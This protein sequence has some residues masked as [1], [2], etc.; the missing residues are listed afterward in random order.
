MTNKFKATIVLTVFL[1][2]P[3]LSLMAESIPGSGQE[4]KIEE[5]TKK[6]YPS[7]VRVEVRNMIKKVATGVVIEKNGYIVTTA[8]ISPRDEKISVITSDGK[9]IDA[10]FLGMDSETHL[11]LIQAKDKNLTP[12]TMGNTKGLSP[13]S[14]IGV[15]SISPENMPA[16]T[17]GIVSSLSQDWLRLNV[18]VVPG[19]SGSPV[20]DRNGRM[21]GLLRG[22]YS[23]DKPIVFE[24]REK[25][26]A[27]SGFIF[28]KAEA[29]SS[30]LALAAPIE[31]VKYVSSEIK[32]K[33][34]VERGWLGVS[35]VNNK[36][37]NVE[38]IDVE[39]ESPAELSKLKKGDII[40]KFEGEDITSNEMLVREIRK[41]KPGDSI[42]LR[43]GRKGKTRDV[44]VRLGEHSEKDVMLEM[45]YKFPRLFVPPEKLLKMPEMPRLMEPEKSLE[46]K[47]FRMI[48]GKRKYIG[49]NLEEINK[50][51]SEYFGVKKGRG[52]LISQ[53]VKDTPAEKAGLKVGDIIFKADGVRIER[54][55]D[56]SKLI[57]NKEKGDRIKIE[58][59]RDR[60]ARSV[61]VEIEEE[62][63]S[64]AFRS[65]SKSWEDY[66][67]YRDDYVNSWNSYSEAIKK[68]YKEWKDSYELNYE[69]QIKKWNK[70]LEKR[71]QESEN[72]TKELLKNL[73]RYKSVKV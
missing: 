53:I 42:T 6:V 57:Q 17:Q 50:E 19:S 45:Q 48:M 59:L 12:I 47:M 30:G 43:V 29:P 72:Y 41:R 39:K 37:G 20:V 34:K 55:R 22:T 11:A 69:K 64:G 71:A 26:I 35:I 62:E 56:L 73:L 49:V 13:G 14:W 5:V 60:K 33:G 28:S 68:K 38:I 63:R 51:L 31:L 1:L 8:L 52:L 21:V 54:R 25:E 10:E 65:Y 58:F 24:F 46:P 18:W 70:K 36:D 40:L 44:E 4:G 61:E 32:E 2:V 67:D 23:D 16:I 66:V 15:V 27:G 9:K 3:V 7:V